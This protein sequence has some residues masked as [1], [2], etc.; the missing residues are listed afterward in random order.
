MAT[1][2]RLELA[3]T[4]RSLILKVDILFWLKGS[5]GEG[6]VLRRNRRPAATELTFAV[7]QRTNSPC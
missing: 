5:Y 3:I 6:S 1:A 7:S 4:N 2:L